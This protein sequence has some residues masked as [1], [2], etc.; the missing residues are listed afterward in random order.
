M[1]C[2]GKKFTVFSLRNVKLCGMSFRHL[3][4]QCRSNVV[5]WKRCMT[6]SKIKTNASE[7]EEYGGIRKTKESVET[8]C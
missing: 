5:W 8:S 7:Y 6:P 3:C 1:S 4:E 2:P